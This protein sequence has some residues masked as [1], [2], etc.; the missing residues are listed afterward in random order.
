MLQSPH[1]ESSEICYQ[2][3]K[4]MFKLKERVKANRA[5]AEGFWDPSFQTLAHKSVATMMGTRERESQRG[6]F[7]VP[8]EKRRLLSL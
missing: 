8:K 5:R 4:T 3:N 7:S 1:N 6:D 2:T